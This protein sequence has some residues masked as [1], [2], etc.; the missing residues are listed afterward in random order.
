MPSVLVANPKGGVGK[1]TVALNLAVA[2]KRGDRPVR[3]WDVDPQQSL[4]DWVQRRPKSLALLPCKRVTQSQMLA[5]PD[6]PKVLD[7]FDLPSGF[8]EEAFLQFCRAHRT[9][10]LIPTSVSPVDM[11]ALTHHLFRLLRGGIQDLGGVSLGMVINRA[12]VRLRLH[13]EAMAWLSKL[14]ISQVAE[15]RDTV[16]YALSA[17]EGLSVLELPERFSSKDRVAWQQLTAWVESELAD[18]PDSAAVTHGR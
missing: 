15:L 12:R 1:T 9:L 11:D 3:L 5:L 6:D 13:R 8:A 2:L 4:W 17:R 14:A 7:I 10:V 16:N 18:A